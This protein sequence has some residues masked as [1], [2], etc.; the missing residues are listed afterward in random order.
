M[1]M[2]TNTAH[3]SLQA[4]INSFGIIFMLSLK[5]Y[6]FIFLQTTPLYFLLTEACSSSALVKLLPRRAA[7]AGSIH[8]SSIPSFIL[9]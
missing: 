9:L 7:V 1:T 4:A 2:L 3:L 8:G 5:S 6:L